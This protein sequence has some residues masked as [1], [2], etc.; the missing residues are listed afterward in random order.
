ME[1][2]AACGLSLFIG[3]IAALWLSRVDLS[4]RAN[5]WADPGALVRNTLPPPIWPP[6]VALGRARHDAETHAHHPQRIRPL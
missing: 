1:V 5:P 4:D 2:H 3:V 6:P